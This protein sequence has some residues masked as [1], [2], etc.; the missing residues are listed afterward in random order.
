MFK[1]IS[2]TSFP[3]GDYAAV[4]LS[5][6]PVKEKAQG[7]DYRHQNEADNL[8]DKDDCT[9]NDRDDEAIKEDECEH[10]SVFLRVNKYVSKCLITIQIYE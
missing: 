4:D 6:K 5:D 10:D 7:C 2:S 9:E 3:P 8:K 1:L